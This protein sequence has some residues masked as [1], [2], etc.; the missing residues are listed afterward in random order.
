M[1]LMRSTFYIHFYLQEI[2]R[3]LKKMYFLYKNL[4]WYFITPDNNKLLKSI[5][6]A[7]YKENIFN[8]INQTFR[9]LQTVTF[10]EPE[11]IKSNI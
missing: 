11:N 4:S 2:E 7:L 6:V 8:Q 9:V 10:G 1:I 5:A 3:K